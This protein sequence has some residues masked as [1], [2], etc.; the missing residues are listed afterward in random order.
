MAPAPTGL[1]AAELLERIGSDYLG[2]KTL[3]GQPLTDHELEMTL[4]EMTDDMAPEGKYPAMTGALRIMHQNLMRHAKV[5]AELLDN[6]TALTASPEGRA[7]LLCAQLALT[8]FDSAEA[9]ADELEQ[10]TDVQADL[11][12][13]QRRLD[14]AKEIVSAR[15]RSQEACP[16]ERPRD[17]TVSLP[18]SGAPGK[19]FEWRR[20]AFPVG[21]LPPSS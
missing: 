13:F 7:S 16:A 20:R 12:R 4:R 18:G 17:I 15:R 2:M 3:L 11:D 8:G 21:N 1:T 9:L 6:L 19:H 5:H 14:E 10:G